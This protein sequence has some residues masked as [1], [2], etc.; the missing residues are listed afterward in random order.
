MYSLRMPANEI[1]SGQTVCKP[2][3]SKEYRLEHEIVIWTEGKQ[4]QTLDGHFLMDGTG[5]VSSLDSGCL[6]EV[7]FGSLEGLVR[8]G[9]KTCNAKEED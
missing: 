3:G 7:R 8:F 5:N 9:A 6:L 2:N 1:P 4:K